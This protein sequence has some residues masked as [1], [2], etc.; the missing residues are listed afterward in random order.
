M[1]GGRP[2]A[3]SGSH[4]GA[5]AVSMRA[6]GSAAAPRHRYVRDGEVPVVH[7]ALG[8]QIVRPDA[9]VHQDKALLEAMRQDLDRERAAREAAERSLHEARANLVTLQTRLAHVE[10]DLQET[11]KQAVVEVA[12]PVAVLAPEP[13]PER[14]R[15]RPRA[16]KPVRMPQPIKWWIKGE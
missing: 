2:G 3:A 10:M 14:L 12:A 1:G 9:S 4:G 5:S 6:A 15:R 13:L 7:A 16:E 11:Q 8:R